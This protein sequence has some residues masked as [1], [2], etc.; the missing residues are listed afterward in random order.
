MLLAVAPLYGRDFHDPYTT[1]DAIEMLAD[2]GPG[3]VMDWEFNQQTF[4]RSDL[5]DFQMSII[6]GAGLFRAGEADFGG[7][8][9]VPRFALG[10]RY[11]AYLLTGPGGEEIGTPHLAWRMMS[12]QFQ[13]GVHATYAISPGVRLL[14]EY[15]R[16]SDHPFSSP[17]GYSLSDVAYDRLAVGVGFPAIAFGSDGRI[18]AAARLA[19]VDLWDAW[20]AQGTDTSR[21]QWK[22]RTGILA[23][24]GLPAPLIAEHEPQVFAE[25][26]PDVFTQHDA[27]GI[28]ATLGARLGLRLA[29]TKTTRVVDGYLDTYFSRDTERAVGEEFP[30]ALVGLGFRVGN[31]SRPLR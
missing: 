11:G 27:D 13:Y 19:Y 29:D 1:I 21:V 24:H 5:D 16:L 7:N 6:G 18:S 2:G 10:M 8:Y 31:A 28:D 26:H 3:A 9:R 12:V 22:L 25:L 4:R 14:A 15:S 20:E 30:V 17:A 23:K